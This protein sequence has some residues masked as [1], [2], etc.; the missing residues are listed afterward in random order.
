MK[1]RDGT[2]CTICLR[3]IEIN[4]E[5]EALENLALSVV[6]RKRAVN[7]SLEGRYGVSLS[8]SR[9]NCVHQ[10]NA[11]QRAGLADAMQHV[12]NLT[13]HRPL[14]RSIVGNDF[15]QRHPSRVVRLQHLRFNVFQ[16][17]GFAGTRLSLKF[18]DVLD[19]R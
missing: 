1:R 3:A 5:D 12:E 10:R 19:D 15:R 7:D 14:S 6:P 16:Q 8:R 17:H 2:R 4:S 11:R 9:A 13:L 18:I